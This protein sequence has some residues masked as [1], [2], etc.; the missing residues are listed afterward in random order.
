MCVIQR[1]AIIAVGVCLGVHSIALANSSRIGH[2]INNG[3]GNAE[4]ILNDL[5]RQLERRLNVCMHSVNPCGLNQLQRQIV[6]RIQENVR[7]A[8]P[9]VDKQLLYKSDGTP[10][11]KSEISEL[12][13]Q[14]ALGDTCSL[15]LTAQ[16]DWA[17]LRER[18]DSVKTFIALDLETVLMHQEISGQESLVLVHKRNTTDLLGR[19]RVRLGITSSQPIR[20]SGLNIRAPVKG[21]EIH[22]RVTDGQ[23]V[24]AAFLILLDDFAANPNVLITE[25]G[26]GDLP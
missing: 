16:I 24:D 20:I 5:S 3:G 9:V 26:R 4:L 7:N 11:S 18:I 2:T 13:L 23:K 8:L 25:G 17:A 12:L 22:G 6:E 21:I 19:V 10:V 15:A 14:A 1:L